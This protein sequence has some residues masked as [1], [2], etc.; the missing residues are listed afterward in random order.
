MGGGNEPVYPR[1]SGRY[2]RWLGGVTL[3]F[4]GKKYEGCLQTGVVGAAVFDNPDSFNFVLRFDRTK[5]LNHNEKLI[6]GIMHTDAYALNSLPIP[7][8]QARRPTSSTNTTWLEGGWRIEKPKLDGEVFFRYALTGKEPLFFGYY[9]APYSRENLSAL[10]RWR[11][12]PRDKAVFSSET[13]LG[14]GSRNRFVESCIFEHNLKRRIIFEARAAFQVNRGFYPILPAPPFG[15]AI[16]R[17]L[18]NHWLVQ[19]GF[20]MPFTV[21]F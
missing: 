20:N 19:A 10:L 18:R 1:G 9:T 13:Y 15:F 7:D 3:N 17:F 6:L 8:P 12:S 16:D 4:P 2:Q 21:K 5:N 14:D 11:I